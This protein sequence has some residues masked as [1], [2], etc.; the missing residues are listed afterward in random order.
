MH[1]RSFIKSLAIASL[2]IVG[3]TACTKKQVAPAPQVPKAPPVP[4]VSEVNGVTSFKSDKWGINLAFPGAIDYVIFND[5]DVFEMRF[6]FEKSDTQTCRQFMS[7]G[8]GMR[9]KIWAKAPAVD[10]D[11]GS[12]LC[13]SFDEIVCR[14]EAKGT[15]KTFGKTDF[16][17]F[18]EEFMDGKT[19]HYYWSY[20]TTKNNVLYEFYFTR[21]AGD[22]T[23]SDDTIKLIL[24]NFS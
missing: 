13:G 7:T 17:L 8:G 12:K 2:L 10:K 6:C 11:F 23:P 24:E 15:L 21:A 19:K 18:P 14:K 1:H 16:A 20:Y 9:A 5:I 4:Q 22:K 3:L